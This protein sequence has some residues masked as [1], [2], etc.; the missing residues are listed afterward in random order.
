METIDLQAKA[1]PLEGVIECYWFENPNVALARTLFH[2]IRIPLAPFD[3]GLDYVS[4]PEETELVVEWIN[5][6]LDDPAE[7]DGIK[8]ATGQN[9]DMEASIYIGA[10]HNWFHIDRLID[11]LTVRREGHRY[12]VS[13]VGTVEFAREGVARDERFAFEAMAVY[14]GAA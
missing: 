12:R 3:S 7:L 13:G 4:Q 5:L 6:G 11:R 10:A 14:R 9:P 1:R 2:R 8:V